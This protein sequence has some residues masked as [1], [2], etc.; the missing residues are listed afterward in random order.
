LDGAAEL[1]A[2]SGGQPLAALE[3]RAQGL[4]AALWRRMP[5]LV[6]TGDAQPLTKL[7][8]PLAIECL[9]KFCHDAMAVAAGAAPRFFQVDGIVVRG[10]TIAALSDWARTLSRSARHAGHPWNAPLLLESLLAQGRRALAG[11]TDSVH[12]PR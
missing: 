11:E 5:A 3:R 10:A 2:A 7:P 4:D 12:S 8:L 6:E 9:H 1:L